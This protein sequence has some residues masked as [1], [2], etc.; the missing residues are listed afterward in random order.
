MDYSFLIEQAKQ[1]RGNSYS[2]YSQFRVG[3][4]LLAKSGKVY[5][6]CNVENTAYGDTVCAERIA[7][8]KA[9]SEGEREFSAIAIVGGKDKIVFCPPCG[10]CRQVMSE[11][12]SPDFCV[13]FYDGEDIRTQT[14]ESLLP[15][16]FEVK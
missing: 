8:F 5:Q 6:G 11:F 12:C 1:A 15:F 2:P 13:I 16:S 7:F 14:L 4:A 3:A 10:S 9:I